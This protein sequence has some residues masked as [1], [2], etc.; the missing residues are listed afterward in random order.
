M[1]PG[2]TRLVLGPP[3]LLEINM[4][5]ETTF[6]LVSPK[7]VVSSWTVASGEGLLTQPA[8]S[9]RLPR[10]TEEGGKSIPG[11]GAACER[12]QR[13]RRRHGLATCQ[14]FHV[15]RREEVGR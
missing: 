12:S 14:D 1:E 7:E 6:Y 2:W 4:H 10:S 15:V 9:G 5:I 11:R 13:H 3:E 8:K